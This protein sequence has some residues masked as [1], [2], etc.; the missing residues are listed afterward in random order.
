ME[1][2]VGIFD[3][4]TDAERAA[5]ALV[6][7]GIAQDRITVVSPGTPG[8]TAE[9]VPTT[10]SEPP[11]IGRA[12][13]AVVGGATG[14][15]TGIQAA[16]VASVL[17]P[18][19]GPVFI[20]GALGALLFGA[21]GAAVGDKLDESLREGLPRDEVPIIEE[22][23]RSGRSVLVALVEPGEQED[24]A[25]NLLEQA[26]AESLD[27]TRERW[28]IGLR[29]AR[30]VEDDAAE[31]RRGFEAALSVQRRGAT[32]AEVADE[33]RMRYPDVHDHEAFRR[34]YERGRAYSQSR[35]SG[36]AA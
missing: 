18:G 15:A 9:R 25:R 12:L 30:E 7:Q 3:R 20:L 11:G 17:I 19:V 13:G 21:A 27:T 32:W 5:Q 31:Y 8:P 4:R 22:A 28:W 23:L 14:A 34:G 6:A 2:V 33:L 26:G 16:A 36:R 29:D 24:S 35:R 1:S 10:E